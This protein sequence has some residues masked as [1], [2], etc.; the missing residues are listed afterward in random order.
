ML[1]DEKIAIIEKPFF[2]YLPTTHVTIAIW[3][4][5]FVTCIKTFH[6]FKLT[7][8]LIII[9]FSFTYFQNISSYF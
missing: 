6:N 1:S 9:I 7:F 5:A 8:N 3:E 2:V 4:L